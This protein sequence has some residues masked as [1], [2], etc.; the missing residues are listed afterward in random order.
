MKLDYFTLFAVIGFIDFIIVVILL[1]YISIVVHRKW[2]LITYSIYKAL[3]SFA[4]I[5]FGL[6]GN[7]SDWFT[8]D[9]ANILYFTF[10]FLHIISVVSYRGHLNKRFAYLAGSISIFC[11]FVFL[12]IKDEG[13]YR[14]I[15]S[16]FG[17]ALSYIIAGI[18]LLMNRKPYKLPILIAIGFLLFG[19]VN[20]GRGVNTI[21]MIGEYRFTDLAMYDTVFV[22]TGLVTILVSSFG[23]LLLLKEVDDSI[24]FRQNKLNKTAFDQSPVSVVITDYEGKIQYVNPNFSQ[25]TGYS[26]E[27]AI[28]NKANILRTPMTPDETFK[29]LWDTI[30]SGE[31]WR[32]EFVNKKKNNEIYYEEAVIAPI[33]DERLNI[34]NF[35]A[36][37]SDITQRKMDEA[38]IQKRNMELSELNNTKDRMFSIIAHDLKGPIG[39]LQ[40]LL[41]IINYDIDKG[42][43]ASVQELLGILKGTARTAFELL[44]NLL[45]WAR[46]QLNA[47]SIDPQTFDLSTTISDAVNLLNGN[48]MQKDIC[49]TKNYQGEF[50]VFA[51]KAMIETVMRNLL[52][53]AIKFTP[54]KGEITIALE[55]KGIDT[56]LTIKDSGIGIEESRA[57]KIF[58]FAKTQSTRGTDGEKGTGLG[59][60]LSRE[61][62]SKNN[63]KIWFESTVNVGSTFYISLPSENPV[64]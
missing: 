41:E 46:S 59:L 36:I 56:I 24:I 29:E 6:R 14:V 16:S 58:D 12:F 35:L 28:G 47:I 62:I 51:D 42:N 45:A 21:F 55:T 2:F 5:G 60:I 37:K 53:N 40:Q 19:I 26:L 25:L 11:I 20:I 23:F 8:V 48:L 38:L 44:D 54:A 50:K 63:G 32:G 43:T 27:E 4:M 52:S 57:E 3:E 64:G 49:L 17:I 18:F 61:F 13:H 15:V 1:F 31:I 30:K 34:V 22:L 9:T 39:N 7:A 33:K 10:T